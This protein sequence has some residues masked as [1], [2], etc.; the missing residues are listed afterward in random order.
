[1]SMIEPQ[2]HLLQVQQERAARDA[3]IALQ[4]GLGIAPE[5][6]DAVDVPAAGGEAFAMVDA[7]VP[8]ALGD[9]PIVA[10]TLVRVDGAALGHLLADHSPKRLPREVRH[11]AGVHLAA[12]LQEPKDGH[13]ARS[14]PAPQSLPVPSEIG[15]VRF[16]L[17][18]EG[19]A[20]LTVPSQVVA[21]DL[22]DALGTVAVDPEHR[23]GLHGGH[24]QREAVDELATLSV[25]YLAT[26]NEPLAHRTSLTS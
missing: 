14:T 13:V 11:G 25:R 19:R 8:V 18:V 16:D 5:V 26:R 20:A 10:G 4:F 12:S 7:V 21:N 15:F 17:S 23:G 3:I 1:M 24:L 2:V 9:Q 22:I 6:L